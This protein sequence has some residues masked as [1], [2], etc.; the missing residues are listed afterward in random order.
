MEEHTGPTGA[1][2]EASSGVAIAG[3]GMELPGLSEIW[4]SR[5]SNAPEEAGVT[6]TVSATLAQ[7]QTNLVTASSNGS[8]S[9][10]NSNKRNLEPDESLNPNPFMHVPPQ[11]L[12]QTGT[13]TLQ[14]IGTCA[15]RQAGAEAKTEATS[16]DIMASGILDTALATQQAGNCI[17]PSSSGSGASIGEVTNASM[18][19]VTSTTNDTGTISS[20]CTGTGT[21]RASK[22]ARRRP[23]TENKRLERNTRE[24]E[25]SNQVSKQ[26][27]EL[28]DLLSKSGIII[29]KGTKMA[30]LGISIEYI[31]ALQEQQKQAEWKNQELASQIRQLA[32]G[33][34]GEQS[35]RAI[36]HA[37]NSNAIWDLPSFSHGQETNP[38]RTAN[39]TA[40]GTGAGAASYNSNESASVDNSSAN[41]SQVQYIDLFQHAPVPMAISSLGGS[42]LDCNR[43]F[44]NLTGLDKDQIKSLTIFNLMAQEDLKTSFERISRMLEQRTTKT[45]DLLNDDVFPLL[46][47]GS[48]ANSPGLGLQITSIRSGDGEPQNLC[49]TLMQL[50]RHPNQ[51]QQQPQETSLALA[52]PPLEANKEE[53]PAISTAGLVSLNDIMKQAMLP[54]HEDDVYRSSPTPFQVIG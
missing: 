54:K 34:H 29:P 20:T 50:N 13:A 43:S 47:K 4:F 32:Q 16:M 23:L 52:S 53:I 46:V 48:F 31:R 26:F 14:A 2:A 17:F 42:L 49:I 36:Q 45:H 7:T 33:V 12:R 24:Q 15:G 51:M 44:A 27:N 30:V 3:G 9:N 39:G 5:L 38:A 19:T 40:N 6:V 1:T 35:L 28:R 10:S 21:G 22:R 18:H 25:R 11:D 8:N 37:G 41:N